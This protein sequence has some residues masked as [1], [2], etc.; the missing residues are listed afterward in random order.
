[1][2]HSKTLVHQALSTLKYNLEKT[3][4]PLGFKGVYWTGWTRG[5]DL[6][7]EGKTLL[8]TARMYQMLPYVVETTELI[9]KSKPLLASQSVARLLVLGNRLAGEPLIR[10]KARR[11]RTLKKRGEH[12][13]GGIVKA[14]SRAG[15][16]PA[17]LYEE[18][19]YSG[20]LL[21]ELGLEDDV[22]PHIARVYERLKKRGVEQIITVDPHTTFMLKDIFPKYIKPYALKIKHYLEC[23][24]GQL[25]MESPRR[26]GI[27]EA[28][29]LHDPCVM[30]R[31]L[32]MTQEAR[33]VL[34]TLNIEPVDTR[35]TK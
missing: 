24:D 13:L 5:L 18:E 35:N 1:M 29:V 19:P 14:L 20:V 17:Y 28:L 33:H 3:G 4:D 30:A 23:L 32:G 31:D 15:I 16:R 9:K 21:Y 26:T 11:S 25:I 7:R 2:K 8:L 12:V 27:P 34:K 6:P 10:L 22:A